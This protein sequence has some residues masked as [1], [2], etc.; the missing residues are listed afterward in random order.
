MTTDNLI[1][2]L[3][4]WVGMIATS[5]PTIAQTC[6]G[7]VRASNPTSSYSV[8]NGTVT[9]L[10]SGLIW[11]QCLWGKSGTDCS[12]GVAST[13]TW[14]QALAVPGTAN[15]AKHR[16]QSDW[17][18]PNIKELASLVEVCRIPAINDQVFP[19]TAADGAWTSSPYML[20]PG[21]GWIVLFADGSITNTSLD[22]NGFTVR[23]VRSGQ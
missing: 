19:A 11:D 17:R 22:S 14:R 4:C 2:L 6:V 8:F 21:Y 3:T 20:F 7:G 13:L 16:G 18:L 1:R 15:A 12:A 23:L 5:T 10:R 9:D